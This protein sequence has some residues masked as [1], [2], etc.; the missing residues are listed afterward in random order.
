MLS[1]FL[2][3]A[4]EIRCEYVRKYI[5]PPA[6]AGVLRLSSPNGLFR[7]QLVLVT[8]REHD[9]FAILGDAI[10]PVD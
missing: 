8:G 4:D 6:T 2:A 9:H 3:A 10:Q 5:R 1:L 7:D